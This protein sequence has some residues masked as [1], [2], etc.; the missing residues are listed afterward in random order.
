MQDIQEALRASQMAAAAA[1]GEV[2]TLQGKHAHSLA[3]LSATNKELSEYK[4]QVSFYKHRDTHLRPPLRKSSLLT[5]ADG[6]CEP[7]YRLCDECLMWNL[8]IYLFQLQVC[9]EFP[10]PEHVDRDL[11]V[12]SLQAPSGILTAMSTGIAQAMLH[13]QVPQ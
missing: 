7:A 3:Q 13:A 8:F 9:P 1:A 10:P 6:V 11:L 2:M 5:G 12:C 4:L